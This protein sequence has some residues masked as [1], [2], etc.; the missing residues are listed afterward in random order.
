MFSSFTF[1]IYILFCLTSLF[2]NSN[3]INCLLIL[4][5]LS[6]YQKSCFIYNNMVSY[7]HFIS[8]QKKSTFNLEYLN[9]DLCTFSIYDSKESLNLYFLQTLQLNLDSLKSSSVAD[10]TFV[11]FDLLTPLSQSKIQLVPY[12]FPRKQVL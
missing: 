7:S 2:L 6:V 4:N 8:R 10:K 5:K 9:V 12:F 3:M 11:N 1:K